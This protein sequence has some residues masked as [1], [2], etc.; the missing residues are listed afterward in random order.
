MYVTD[1]KRKIDILYNYSKKFSNRIKV[2][3]IG[4]SMQ[5]C[6]FCDTITLDVEPCGQVFDVVMEVQIITQGAT[7]KR[8][9]EISE[10]DKDNPENNLKNNNSNENNTSIVKAN[11]EEDD[12]DCG[13]TTTITSNYD[14]IMKRSTLNLPSIKSH[15]VSQENVDKDHESKNGKSQYFKYLS[16]SYIKL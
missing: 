1:G 16:K 5:N 12:D 2:P 7:L 9:D 10:V 6:S 13:E 3:S 15:M 14:F 8:D 4:T 11:D